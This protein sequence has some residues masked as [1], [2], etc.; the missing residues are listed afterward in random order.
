MLRGLFNGRAA[1]MK[2]NPV[3]T[4][5]FASVVL[6]VID[7][8]EGFEYGGIT[9]DNR[10]GKAH[11]TAEYARWE[12]R[13]TAWTRVG[14]VLITVGGLIQIASLFVSPPND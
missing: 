14:I 4:L 5:N 3:S 12:P 1:T 13:N 2:F 9:A 6:S 8:F 7:R 10:D 11:K